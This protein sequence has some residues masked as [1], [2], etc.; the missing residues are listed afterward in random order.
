MSNNV[1]LLCYKI[2]CTHYHIIYASYTIV[3]IH[4]RIKYILVF[5]S[6]PTLKIP[7]V[8]ITYIFHKI[9]FKNNFITIYK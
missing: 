3:N 8:Y 6:P 1:S 4:R 9:V 2:I 5:Y 7:R